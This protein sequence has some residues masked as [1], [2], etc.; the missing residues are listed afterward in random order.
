MD[1][2]SKSVR[3]QA[4]HL[5]ELNKKQKERTGKPH[6]EFNK[7]L[8]SD[9]QL[10]LVV[11]A[12]RWTVNAMSD[13][14]RRKKRVMPNTGGNIEHPAQLTVLCDDSGAGLRDFVDLNFAE[15]MNWQVDETQTEK[16]VM[17]DA[18][19][20]ETTGVLRGDRYLP[21][22]PIDCEIVQVKMKEGASVANLGGVKEGARALLNVDRCLGES[23]RD[24]L[25][26]RACVEDG[27]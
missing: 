17:A 2:D 25:V 22:V 18:W 14:D 9:R 11:T 27:W 15:Y 23:R 4:Q 10:A 20:F 5:S 7:N 1:P 3:I 19:Y 26:H 24:R 6:Y 8:T 16:I 21:L 13:L 12:C